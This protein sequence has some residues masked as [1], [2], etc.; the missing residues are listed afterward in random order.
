[1]YPVK[2]VFRMASPSVAEHTASAI[3]FDDLVEA[4]QAMVF[5]IAYHFLH[6]RAAAEEVAQDAFL[7]LY[8]HLDE[9]DSPE[10]IVFW[11][12]RVTANRCIDEARRRQRRNEISLE[13]AG[14]PASSAHRDEWMNVRLRRLVASLPEKQRMMV[15]LRYQEDLEPMEIASLL[16]MPVNTVKSQ[17]QRGLRLLREKTGVGKKE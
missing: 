15:V 2:E 3:R 7:Q 4:H 8:F 1:M 17:L 16:E 14:D 5:S 12:R 11:L 9:I 6:D 13:A 10:H